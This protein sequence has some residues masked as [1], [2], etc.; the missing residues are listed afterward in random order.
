[1]NRNSTPLSELVGFILKSHHELAQLNVSQTPHSKRYPSV[2][3]FSASAGPDGTRLSYS[4]NAAG[5]MK[6]VAAQQGRFYEAT[7]PCRGTSLKDLQ[8]SIHLSTDSGTEAFTVTGEEFLNGDRIPERFQHM[9]Q[10]IARYVKQ[11][12][13]WLTKDG[14]EKPTEANQQALD[15]SEVLASQTA[16]ASESAK[17]I[18][19]MYQIRPSSGA[20]IRFEGKRIAFVESISFKGRAWQFS[21]FE[22]K[23]GANVLVKRGISAWMGEKETVEVE[24]TKRVE[25]FRIRLPQFFGDSAAARTLYE[26]VGF[27]YVTMVD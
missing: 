5:V 11:H 7:L 1:M 15:K 9:H 12:L 3:D 13:G 25:D 17:P 4:I 20:D 21:V 18:M 26:Q 23:G 6:L 14:H 27:E 19:K 10:L 22:T 24:V 2:F 8:A 16:P